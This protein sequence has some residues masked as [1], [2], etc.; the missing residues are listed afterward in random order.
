[1]NATFTADATNIRL[2]EP[3]T[4]LPLDLHD[5]MLAATKEPRRRKALREYLAVELLAGHLHIL[6]CPLRASSVCYQ[7]AD[8][9]INYLIEAG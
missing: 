1:M 7:F 2:S 9:L 6:S 8:D 3:N 5:L 4:S